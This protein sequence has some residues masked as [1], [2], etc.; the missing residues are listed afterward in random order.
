MRLFVRETETVGNCNNPFKCVP[1]HDRV[2]AKS[3]T[4]A[5]AVLSIYAVDF[6]INAGW[7]S[8]QI[9]QTDRIAD[10]KSSPVFVPKSHCRHSANC[11]AA[12]WFCLGY[13][14]LPCIRWCTNTEIL[15]QAG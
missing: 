10:A 13:A 6:A 9:E 3:C 11:K 14:L 15:K 1:A 7:C 12:A 2:Q 4:I 5:L 8:A